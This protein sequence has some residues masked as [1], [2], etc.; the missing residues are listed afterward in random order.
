MGMRPHVNMTKSRGL[1][2]WVKVFL[3]LIVLFVAVV[4]G[5]L[6]CQQL[7]V[8]KSTVSAPTESATVL[9]SPPPAFED[10]VLAFPEDPVWSGVLKARNPEWSAS[11]N[12]ETPQEVVVI[13]GFE[14]QAPFPM[15][16]K[17]P[18]GALIW[19][20]GSTVADGQSY[21]L[22]E[23]GGQEPV[24]DGADRITMYTVEGGC[25]IGTLFVPPEG[26]V[27]AQR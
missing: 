27:F 11:I 5:V 21:K 23:Y 14:S 2:T 26:T 10:Y 20:F 13:G 3:A 25:Q 9:L 22:A 24:D 7:S 15:T 1:K 19:P 18:V 12:L 8:H 6:A 17:L 16:C 4:I